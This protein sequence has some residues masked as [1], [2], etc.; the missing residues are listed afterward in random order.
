M[1]QKSWIQILLNLNSITDINNSKLYILSLILVSILVASSITTGSPDSRWVMIFKIEKI[2]AIYEVLTMQILKILKIITHRESGLPVVKLL[3]CLCYQYFQMYIL[4]ATSH[5][6]CAMPSAHIRLTHLNWSCFGV[7]VLSFQN[8][9]KPT[10]F[11]PLLCTLVDG[12]GNGTVDM[13]SA[14]WPQGPLFNSWLCQGL[15]WFVQ[16]SFFPKLTQLSVPLGNR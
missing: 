8:P 3:A 11:R 15:N 9:L 14:F 7:C 6:H 10:L 16:P 12:R 13:I 5:K 1:L 2:Y 4:I